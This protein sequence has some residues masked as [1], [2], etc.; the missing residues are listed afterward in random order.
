VQNA[1][2]SQQQSSQ[3]RHRGS[4]STGVGLND[5]ERHQEM[6][7][8]LTGSDQ[9]GIMRRRPGPEMSLTA[10]QNEALRN[11]EADFGNDELLD[12]V[13]RSVTA[14]QVDPREGTPRRRRMVNNKN[15]RRTRT[16][17]QD[18]LADLNILAA[19]GNL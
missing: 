17:R 18:Q 19:N 16:I 15:L 8:M 7:K 13:V 3:R 5:K 12:G 10:S 2:S 6:S 14:A 4:A 11:S 1:N 9:D